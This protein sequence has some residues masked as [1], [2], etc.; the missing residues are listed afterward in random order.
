MKLVTEEQHIDYHFGGL[1]DDDLY[2]YG[3]DDDSDDDYDSYDSNDDGE[4]SFDNGQ[5]GQQQDVS[6]ARSS[7]EVVK[8]CSFTSS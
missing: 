7:M 6:T 1:E 3:D 4:L 2:N 5:I 8:L